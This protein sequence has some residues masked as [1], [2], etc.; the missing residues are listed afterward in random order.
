MG[1]EEK[2]PALAHILQT[3]LF[4]SFGLKEPTRFIWVVIP[5]RTDE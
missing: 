5:I 1:I 3:K 2:T 4:V